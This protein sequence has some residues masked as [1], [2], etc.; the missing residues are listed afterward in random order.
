ML[1]ALAPAKTLPL[2]DDILGALVICT[3]HGAQATQDAGGP[4]P[5]PGPA[6]HCPACTLIPQFALAVTL[7]ATAIAFA[8]PPGARRM[9]SQSRPMAF[10]IGPGGIRSRAPPLRA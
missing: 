2:V 8:P 5:P 7:L 9:P 3:A 6:S 10:H 1:A 4:E